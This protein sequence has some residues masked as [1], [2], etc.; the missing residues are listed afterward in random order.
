M[1]KE[2]ERWKAIML[3]ITATAGALAVAANV[4][5]SYHDHHADKRYLKVADAQEMMYQQ[6]RYN[7]R[8][9]QR[10]LKYLEMQTDDPMLKEQLH[11]DYNEL[12]MEIR[13]AEADYN[14]S[15]GK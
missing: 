11:K 6:Q 10:S 12:E 2:I 3:A 7:K 8:M 1:I 4:A 9:E 13:D 14:R 5:M 15:R